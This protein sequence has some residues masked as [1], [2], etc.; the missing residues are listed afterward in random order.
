M[1]LTTLLSKMFIRFQ[2]FP[3]TNIDLSSTVIYHFN[4]YYYYRYF[5][6]T[7]INR[8]NKWLID[9]V[10][11]FQIY[12]AHHHNRSYHQ[13]LSITITLL[14]MT[15]MMAF[16]T[17]IDKMNNDNISSVQN[18][19]PND[20]YIANKFIQNLTIIK[21]DS[22]IDIQTDR[23]NIDSENDDDDEETHESH[24]NLCE[25]MRQQLKQ[26]WQPVHDTDYNV[27]KTNHHNY[28]H[29][30]HNNFHSH[31]HHYVHQKNIGQHQ[32]EIRTCGNDDNDDDSCFYL[33]TKCNGVSDCPNGFDESIEMCGMYSENDFF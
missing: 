18:F 23:M 27:T 8:Y 21:N 1:I 4:C 6:S 25:L 12:F 5:C 19:H 7:I 15:N 13:V 28:Y 2:Y 17:T 30:N 26:R 31:H 32:R 9:T 11:N 20:Y 24:M 33:D 29:H 10:K 16:A 22:T 14:F 3:S